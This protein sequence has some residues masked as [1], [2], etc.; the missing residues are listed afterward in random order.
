MTIEFIANNLDIYHSKMVTKIYLYILHCESEK[1]Y[2]IVCIFF[3]KCDR[4]FFGGNSTSRRKQVQLAHF[5]TFRCLYKDAWAILMLIP[6]NR[7]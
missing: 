4:Q 1:T 5:L 2:L 3:F 6:V 7:V